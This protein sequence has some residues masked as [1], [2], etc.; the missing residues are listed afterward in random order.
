MKNPTAHALAEGFDTDGPTTVGPLVEFKAAPDATI[1]VTA[2]TPRH[3]PV[4]NNAFVL[5]VQRTDGATSPLTA[6]L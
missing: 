3:A 1:G 4:S 2:S 6:I 5:F